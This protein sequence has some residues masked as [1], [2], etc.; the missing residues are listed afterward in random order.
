[1]AHSVKQRLLNHSR[2]TGESF[3]LVLVRFGI[4]R[5]CPWNGSLQAWIHARS[6]SWQKRGV[7]VK[8][9]IACTRMQRRHPSSFFLHPSTLNSPCQ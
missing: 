7:K 9:V 2:A 3:H 6:S 1:M 8:S 4:E 5:H